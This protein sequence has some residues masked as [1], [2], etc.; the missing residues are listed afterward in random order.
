M[1]NTYSKIYIQIVFVVKRRENLIHSSFRDELQKYMCGIIEKRNTKTLAIYCMPDHTHILVG[2]KPSTNLSD[3]VRDVKA[4]SSK[5]IND[6]KWVKGKFEWQNGFG[7]FSYGHPQL[8][9][10]I[11]YINNQEEHHRIKTFR[12]E[13]VEFL[14]DYEV[15]YDNAWLFEE[16]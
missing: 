7:A 1:P 10:I 8:G 9:M 2:L 5:F 16:L 4:G 3:L 14:N 12:E 13:Y 6:N 15:P 11:N